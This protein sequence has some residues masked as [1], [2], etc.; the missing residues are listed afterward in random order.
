[1]VIVVTL[2]EI[3]DGDRLLLKKASR[4]ISKNKW[5][6][7]GGKVE[8]G[9]TPLEC[10]VREAFEESGLLIKNPFYHGVINFHDFGSDSITWEGHVF[11][12]RQYSGQLKETEEGELRWFESV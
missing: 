4:G 10:A 8:A 5:N 7:L 3:I 12:A 2:V 11:S 6:G 9:E 1:M